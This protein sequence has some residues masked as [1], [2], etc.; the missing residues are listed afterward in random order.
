MAVRFSVLRTGRALLP[1]NIIFLFLMLI[2]VR[3]WVKPQSLVR[4]EGL[5]KL[6]TIH[7]PYRVSNPRPSCLNHYTTSC[8]LPTDRWAMKFLVNRLLLTNV[9]FF[10]KLNQTHHYY[11]RLRWIEDRKEDVWRDG[12]AALLRCNHR[13]RC[14]GVDPPPRH[15]LPAGV[16]TRGSARAAPPRSIDSSAQRCNHGEVSI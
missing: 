1:R 14:N 3:G 2:S 16:H 15:E 5:G 6:K 9:A 7:S 8:L 12:P 10:L 13:A 4:Q 11:R